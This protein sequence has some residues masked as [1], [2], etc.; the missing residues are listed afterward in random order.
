MSCLGPEATIR[1]KDA[2]SIGGLLGLPI[3]HTGYGCHSSNAATSPFQLNNRFHDLSVFFFS[4]V[5]IVFFLLEAGLREAIC[6][7]R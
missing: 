1:R 7:T 2:E 4:I 3:G 6:F 5:G